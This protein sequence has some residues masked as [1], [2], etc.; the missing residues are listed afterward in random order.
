MKRYTKGEQR[1]TMF[2]QNK[3]S[4][5]KL[6]NYIDRHGP[7]TLDTLRLLCRGHIPNTAAEPAYFA[8]YAIKNGWLVGAL[9]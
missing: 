9:T 8:N 3:E 1:G 5:D 4:L 6:W 7:Q 2:P